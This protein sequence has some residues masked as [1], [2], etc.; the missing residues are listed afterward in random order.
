M[1][2]NIKAKCQKGVDNQKGSFTL[3]K[4]A[5]TEFNKILENTLV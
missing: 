1:T 3:K 5:A 2:W 4:N